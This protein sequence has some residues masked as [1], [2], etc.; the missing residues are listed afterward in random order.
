MSQPYAVICLMIVVALVPACRSKP[1][2]DSQ[3]KK[4]EHKP[5]KSKEK[6]KKKPKGVKRS[7]EYKWVLSKDMSLPANR[8]ALWQALS[9]AKE[10]PSATDLASKEC[11][12]VRFLDSVGAKKDDK[13]LLRS[14]KVVVRARAEFSSPECTGTVSA[15]SNKVTLKIRK[16]TSAEVEQEAQASWVLE[17][18]SKL[19]QDWIFE[20]PA[21]PPK[22]P[23]VF[24]S[25]SADKKTPMSEKMTLGDIKKLFPGSLGALDSATPLET[26]CRSAFEKRW[27]LK[28]KNPDYKESFTVTVWYPATSDVWPT[29]A[30]PAMV[31]EISF[32]IKLK[33]DEKRSKMADAW[34]HVVYDRLN[35]AGLLSAK[36]ISKTQLVYEC[37]AKLRRIR[38]NATRKP[39]RY[40]SLEHCG[41]K[42]TPTWRA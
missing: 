11:R 18:K 3:A 21:T 24:Y 38:K 17:N 19:E 23:S 37:K 28:S 4:T 33:K 5:K 7:R 36:A 22:E 27:V 6:E 39:R 12:M 30:P 34:A 40:I 10:T 20:P 35:K 9:A 26:S 41:L 8:V 25:L 15:K 13:K 29:P 14:N 2:T 42:S 16:S 32:G 1:K 31:S